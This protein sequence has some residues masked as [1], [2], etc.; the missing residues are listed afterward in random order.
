MVYYKKIIV[1][2]II[3]SIIFLLTCPILSYADSVYSDFHW[4]SQDPT[5][6][7]TTEYDNIC[8]RF[9][10]FLDNCLRQDNPRYY[11]NNLIFTDQILPSFNYEKHSYYIEMIDDKTFYLYIIDPDASITYNDGFTNIYVN[12][13]YSKCPTVVGLI[14]IF[15]KYEIKFDTDP[16]TYIISDVSNAET[17]HIPQCLLF[18][19]SK[20]LEDY[21]YAF[22]NGSTLSVLNDIKKA[23]SENEGSGNIGFNVSSMRTFL[24]D[25]TTDDIDTNFAKPSYNSTEFDF[26]VNMLFS[27][28][29]N[30]FTEDDKPEGTDIQFP[31]LNKKLIIN[32]KTLYN[33]LNSS[34]AGTNILYVV[35]IFWNFIIAL[36]IFKDL[37]SIINDIRNGDLLNKSD[38]NIKTEM[39]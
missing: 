1:L 14:D 31:I 3:I 24:E 30:V 29:K 37:S 17:L 33:Y 20:T 27:S 19:K 26:R 34:P 28:I 38:I 4:Y 2:F 8:T 7:I 25:E 13:T 23:L 22:E 16:F 12:D 32:S 15:T 36:Y 11:D 10:T 9:V 6:Y 35:K 5:Y 18:R 21:C 39:L